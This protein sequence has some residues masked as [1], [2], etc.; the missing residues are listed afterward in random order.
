MAETAYGLVSGVCEN[1]ALAFRGIPFAQP[2]I[3]ALRFKP[4]A[5]PGPWIGIRDGAS[6]GHIAPQDPDSLT[7]LIPECRWLF[8]APSVTQSEDC[9]NLNVWSPG[10][11]ESRPVLVWIHGG[12]FL[13]GSGTSPWLDGAHL[14]NAHDVVVVTINYRLGVLGTLMLEDSDSAGGYSC[15]N[16]LLDQIAALRWIR[17]N[18]SSFGGDPKRV[19][20]A[21]GSAGAMSVVALLAT[22]AA[23]GLFSGAIVQS[24][25]ANMVDSTAAA[26]STAARVLKILN[27]AGDQTAAK[28]VAAIETHTLLSAQR[29]VAAERP[30]PFRFA[31]D[32][33]HMPLE[34][35]AAL[36]E[37]SSAPPPLLIGTNADENKLFRA[38]LSS[39]GG[40][41]PEGVAFNFTPPDGQARD[42][43]QE[44]S[45]DGLS[46]ED[47]WDVVNTDLDW[48][49]PVRAFADAYVAAGGNVYLY[50]FAWPTCVLDGRL[51]ACHALEVPFVFDN[52]H[53]LGVDAFVGA[54]AS[55]RSTTADLATN[56]GRY[57]M[58]FVRNG[59]PDAKG[60]PVWP[61]Y[62]GPG[63][64]LLVL[65]ST[66]EARPDPH[67]KRVD[68][69]LTGATLASRRHQ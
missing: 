68:R 40:G 1:G 67:R 22:P 34:P 23:E 3:G 42:V 12:A 2:P 19:C 39:S 8:Y 54:E 55:G 7:T 5:A 43:V 33:V 37:R 49:A 46:V 6:Y 38:V 29:M 15:N 45:R 56:I 13:G 69:W 27:L 41:T 32:G 11:A 28:S 63:G 21:G 17:D 44:L 61:R 58:T 50:E 14:A 9:L 35:L 64:D 25:H 65:D 66:I 26:R 57:W 31:A 4:P 59:A 51:G 10:L 53:Q 36:A 62:S 16:G 30:A 18:I 20:I 47:A 60:M 24:G 52:L 48:R